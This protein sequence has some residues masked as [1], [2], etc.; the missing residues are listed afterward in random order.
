MKAFDT[1]IKDIRSML[2]F[3]VA[4]LIVAE[5]WKQ[6]VY[7]SAHEWLKKT[8]YLYVMEQYL[9]IKKNKFKTLADRCIW[10]TMLSEIYQSLYVI[11]HFSKE[12][13]K[14]REQHRMDTRKYAS[15]RCTGVQEEKVEYGG[16]PRGTQ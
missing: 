2:T 1:E 3:I 12:K 16:R 15:Y 7:P 5:S 8:W 14:Q 13:E 9:S 4:Q 6:L 10:S 11:T